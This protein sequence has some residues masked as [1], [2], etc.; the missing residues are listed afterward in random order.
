MSAIAILAAI[1]VAFPRPGQTLPPVDCTYMS[2]AVPRGTVDLVVQGRP[3]EVYKTGGWVTMVDVAEGVNSIEISANGETTNVTVRVERKPEPKLDSAGNPAST[4]E[5]IY[6]KLPYAADTARAHPAGRAP[7]DVTIVIDPGHGGEKDT[8][9]VSPHGFF[10]KEANLLLAKEVQRALTNMGYKVVMTRTNDQALVLLERPRE[11]C[12]IG[13]DAFV[14]I[15]HNATTCNKDPRTVRYTSVYKWNPIG[16]RL[17]SAISR[18]VGAAL[19]GD[20]P[21]NGVMHANFAVTRNPEVPSCL[22]EA[23]FITTPEGEEAI[24]DYKRRRRI[25]EAIAAGID[26]WRRG[27]E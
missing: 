25:G 4:P 15:H 24:W 8:G 7:E 6:E 13:A 18:R 23:D 21:D 14:S 5:R 3:V 2:G 10:E 16:E 22:V 1:S 19:E 27:A 11:A 26:D 12:R 17:A 9:A 20:V